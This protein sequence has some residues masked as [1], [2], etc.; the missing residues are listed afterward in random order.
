MISPTSA[1]SSRSETYPMSL[2]MSLF[3]SLRVW[4]NGEQVALGPAAQRMVLAALALAGGQVVSQTAL[5]EDL[6][7]GHPP[8]Q[9]VNIVHTYVKRLRHLLE[10]ERRPRQPSGV[11]TR[12]G[13]GY[14]LRLGVASVDAWRFRSLVHDARTARLHNDYAAVEV[15]LRR[16]L[17]LWHAPL[18]EDLPQFRWHPRATATLEERRTAICWYAQ[19]VYRQGRSDEALA[20]VAEAAEEFPLDE[21]IHAWL[22]RVYTAVGRRVDGLRVYREFSGRLDRELG[23][24][25]GPELAELHE[26]ITGHVPPGGRGVTLPSMSSW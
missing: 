19:A 11:V 8:R 25:V 13:D 18:L 22:I 15:I 20:A 16:A 23:V 6:W 17:D 7:Q 5:I 10:P 21:G 3:G 26:S 1:A 14:A 9:A 4:R 2:A 24:P 12:A